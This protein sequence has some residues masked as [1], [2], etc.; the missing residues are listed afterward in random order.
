[1]LTRT[2]APVQ[3]LLLQLLRLS[4]SPP[5]YRPNPFSCLLVPDGETGLKIQRR[6]EPFF[7]LCGCF[8]VA[9]GTL[10][11]MSPAMSYDLH[12]RTPGKHILNAAGTVS[13]IQKSPT[14]ST[15]DGRFAISSVRGR[16][17]ARHYM[18]HTYGTRQ[19]V[20]KIHDS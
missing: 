11:T 3:Q 8:D 2:Q 6:C 13:I 7:Q 18:N 20:M 17:R 1:M 14:A 12:A 10:Q 16:T 19:N 5:L 9:L 15:D 4:K